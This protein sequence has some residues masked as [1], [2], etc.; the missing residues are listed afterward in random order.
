MLSTAMLLAKYPQAK[1]FLMER[2]WSAEKIESMPVCQTV[3]IAALRQYNEMRDDMFKGLCLPYPEAHKEAKKFEAKLHEIMQNG[4]E[5][6]PIGSILLPAVSAAKNAEIRTERE[7]VIL[8]VFEAIRLYGAAHDGKLP[9]RLSDI[10]EVP[11][12]LDPF[13]GTAFIYNRIGDTAILESPAPSGTPIGY[14]LR[15]EIRFAQKGK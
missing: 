13:N 12:P 6:M 7:I 15:Y 2:G 11:V 3:L 9:D 4:E 10:T 1:A 8:R 14:W 5:I